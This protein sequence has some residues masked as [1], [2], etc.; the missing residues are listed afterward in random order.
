[1]HGVPKNL[2]LDRFHGATLVQIALGEFQ[3]QFVFSK[4]DLNISVEGDWAIRNPAAEI[5]DR[6]VPNEQ[7][8]SFKVHRLLGRSIASSE[9]DPPHSFTL[10]VDNGWILSVF[11]DSREYES[12]SINLGSIYV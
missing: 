3:V 11:D 8:D 6:S 1:M 7:R 2:N 4:P 9:V 5:V 12:F 10:R